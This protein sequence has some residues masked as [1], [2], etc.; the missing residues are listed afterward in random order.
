MTIEV[1]G[2]EWEAVVVQARIGNARN[3]A[4]MIDRKRA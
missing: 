4:V 2:S 1:S 3:R